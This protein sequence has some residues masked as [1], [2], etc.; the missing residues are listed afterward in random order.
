MHY[1]GRIRSPYTEL[2]NM[3]IQPRGAANVYGTVIIDEQYAEGLRDLEGFSHIYL[4]YE[5]HKATRTELKVIP[6]MDKEVRGVYATRSPLRPNHIGL[7]IVELVKREGTEL[8]IRGVDI[9]DQTPLFDIKP[10]I[11]QFD[12]VTKSRSGWLRANEEEVIQKRS[13]TSF[14]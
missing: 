4:L 5:F 11:S 1:I 2:A 6:F 3:P 12:N 13:D 9:L 8:T 7:S 14:T 10:Y